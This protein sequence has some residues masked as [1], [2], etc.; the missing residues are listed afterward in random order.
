MRILKPGERGV[1][2][3]FSLFLSSSFLSSLHNQTEEWKAIS[4]FAMA[5]K[6]VQ[7]Q[8]YNRNGQ[9]TTYINFY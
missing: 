8:N 7:I 3:P 1:K 2:L 4:L 5:L 9:S 6:H